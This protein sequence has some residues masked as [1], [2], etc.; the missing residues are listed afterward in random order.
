MD[1]FEFETFLQSKKNFEEMAAVTESISLQ[2]PVESQDVSSAMRTILHRLQGF[3]V[4]IDA[5][6]DEDSNV[7]FID[8]YGGDTSFKEV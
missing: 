1:L 6:V 3:G 2:R 4:A 7:I 5:C 8:M